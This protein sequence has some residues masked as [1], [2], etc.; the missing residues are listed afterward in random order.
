VYFQQPLEEDGFTEKLVF[1]DEAMFHVHGKVNH[2]NVCIWGTENPHATVEHV[3][4]L[5]KV[6]AYF[7]VSSCK[8]YRPFFFVEPTVNGETCKYAMVPSTQTW[9]DSLPI[10]MLLSVVSVFCLLCC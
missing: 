1:S 9:R 3:H 5:P 8:V 2:H 7:A 6:N 4:N 10:D